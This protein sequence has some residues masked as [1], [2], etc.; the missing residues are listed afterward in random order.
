[1]NAPQPMSPA[2]A[3]KSFWRHRRA[4]E[5]T[6]SGMRSMSLKLSSL[7]PI[8]SN[9][10]TKALGETPLQPPPVILSPTA[11]RRARS[12]SRKSTTRGGP[13]RTCGEAR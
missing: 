11:A 9:L 4:S 13:G 5:L 1:M 2:L 3:C 10:W 7:P 12:R 6:P 8:E